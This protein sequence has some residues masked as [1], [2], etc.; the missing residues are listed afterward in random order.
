[1]ADAGITKQEIR[2]MAAGLPMSVAEKPSQ[3]CLATRIGHG[4][5]LEGELL[6]AVEKIEICFKKAGCWH[7][8]CRV[9]DGNAAIITGDSCADKWLACYE[10]IL[11]MGYNCFF[12]ELSLT[13]AASG[14]YCY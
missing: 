5:K 3:S 12:E 10:N 2:H 1:M 11:T 9:D 8:R 7:V 4:Q 6:E 14:Y 13:N